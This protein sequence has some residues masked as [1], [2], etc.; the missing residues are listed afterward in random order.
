MVNELFRWYESTQLPIY[1]PGDK[2]QGF[3]G[4]LPTNASGSVLCHISVSKWCYANKLEAT[5][6]ERSERC[7]RITAD[8]CR[9]A[10]E[11]MNAKIKQGQ[12]YKGTFAVQP[13]VT[14]CGECHMTKGNDANW[15]KGV[16]DCTPCHNGGAALTDKFNNHP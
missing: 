12:D 4:E 6:K 16:M 5:S 3:K 10:I 7:G 11:I 15:A 14:G 8:V 1:N 9:K 13:A 2:A